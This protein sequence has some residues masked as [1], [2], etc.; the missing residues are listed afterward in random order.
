MA[1]ID[2]MTWAVVGLALASVLVLLGRRQKSDAELLFA[3]FCGSLAMVLL[4]PTLGDAPVAIT[5]LV[6]LGACATCNVYWLVARALFRGDG[7]VAR[8]HVAAAAGVAVLIVLYRAGEAAGIGRGLAV[9]G[10]LLT[11]ASSTV[12][13]LA[14]AEALRGWAVLPVP[15]RRLRAAYLLVYGGCVVGGTASG[16]MAA[17]EPA[18]APVHRGIVL[19]CSA[20]ILGFTHVALLLRRRQRG[21]VVPAT[22]M[23]SSSPDA[24]ATRP[25]ASVEDLALAAA[26]RRVLE[27]QALYREPELK[28]ADLAAAVGSV[29]H[30]VSRAITQGLG[31]RNFNQLVNRYRIEYACRQL[32]SHE[33]KTVLEISLDSGFG[34]LGPFNRA[35]NAATGLTPTAWRAARRHAPAAAL[36]ADPSR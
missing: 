18:W 15:E 34:S 28:V 4:R 21:A 19:G 25:R 9:L 20:A 12:L 11:L 8:R 27:Q 10:D 33:G 1:A 3:V 29:E 17:S 36:T 32:A 22:P 6:T 31:E 24:V 14:F 16:A 7:A 30:K 23:A 13:V 5:A 2:G 35:F 26:I